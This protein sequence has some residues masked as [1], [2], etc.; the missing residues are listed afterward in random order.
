MNKNKKIKDS[1]KKTALKKLKTS[2][3]RRLLRSKNNKRK[4]KMFQR[5]R[6]KSS[7]ILLLQIRTE[8]STLM[9]DVTSFS[10]KKLVLA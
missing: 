3:L 7:R 4:M 1:S 10:L 9:V 6:I 2:A 5:R 8:L